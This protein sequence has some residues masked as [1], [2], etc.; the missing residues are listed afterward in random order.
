MT[1]YI[2]SEN[3]ISRNDGHGN[4]TQIINFNIEKENKIVKPLMVV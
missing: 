1:Y 4:T 2:F 3:G